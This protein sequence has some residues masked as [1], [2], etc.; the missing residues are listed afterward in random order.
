MSRLEVRGATSCQYALFMLR[1]LGQPPEAFL[2]GPNLAIGDAQL[3]RAGPDR[4]LR[5]NLK[6]VHAALNDARQQR[7]LTWGALAE[8]LD[9]TPGRLTG[10]RSATLADLELVMRITQW[11]QRPAADFIHPAPW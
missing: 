5:W 4:R 2:T 11:L 8:Q 9:C 10:L 7:A 1:W 6:E 3:P